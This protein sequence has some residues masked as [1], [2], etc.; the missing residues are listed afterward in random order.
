M[1]SWSYKYHT[2]R[3]P[4]LYGVNMRVGVRCVRAGVRCVRTGR[5][6]RTRGACGVCARGVRCVRA[7]RAV[8]AHGACGAYARGVRPAVRTHG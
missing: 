2:V 3:Y 6:V 8:C 4:D 5:A 1:S 7:G